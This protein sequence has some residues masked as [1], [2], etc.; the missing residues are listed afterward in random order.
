LPRTIPRSVFKSST[1]D[2]NCLDYRL[3][4]IRP[5]DHL[6]FDDWSYTREVLG[7]IRRLRDGTYPRVSH[8]S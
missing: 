8:L 2:L 7:L 3:I 4:D 5:I 6:S 1:K